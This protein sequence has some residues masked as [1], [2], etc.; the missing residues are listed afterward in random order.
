MFLLQRKQKIRKNVKFTD[1]LSKEKMSDASRCN[2]KK[3]SLDPLNFLQKIV[4]FITF[5]LTNIFQKKWQNMWKHILYLFTYFSE[6]YLSRNCGQSGFSRKKIALVTNANSFMIVININCI[7]GLKRKY[8]F[9]RFE[10]RILLKTILFL[11]W[12]NISKHF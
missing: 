12:Q 11:S 9:W 4:R 3:K 2:L 5:L 1:S 8:C 7:L 6:L 10:I